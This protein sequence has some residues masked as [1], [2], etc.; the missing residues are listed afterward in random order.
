MLEAAIS[1]YIG[2][3]QGY[4]AADRASQTHAWNGLLYGTPRAVEK[5]ASPAAEL[6]SLDSIVDSELMLRE[7]FG[8]EGSISLNPLECRLE[9]TR[10]PNSRFRQNESC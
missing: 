8:T 7:S 1:S 6:R 5:P 9:Y 2:D 3:F 4:V 10:T